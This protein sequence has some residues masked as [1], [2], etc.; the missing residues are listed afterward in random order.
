MV[1]PFPLLILLFSNHR[2]ANHK[3]HGFLYI[4]FHLFLFVFVSLSYLPSF[5]IFFFYF[6]HNTFPFYP[7]SSIPC[8]LLGSSSAPCL[9]SSITPSPI[10]TSLSNRNAPTSHRATS[11]Q[12][13]HTHS[14]QDI[15][16]Y[17]HRLI[18]A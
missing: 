6:C 16:I 4:F 11:P 9:L 17:V 14:L 15:Y 12:P 8:H 7:H 13:P 1:S 5:L 2:V 18:H 10:D 3:I